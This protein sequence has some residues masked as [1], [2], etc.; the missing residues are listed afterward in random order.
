M[1]LNDVWNENINVE[2][3]PDEVH[4]E[5][6]VKKLANE[7]IRMGTY[8]DYL[9]DSNDLAEIK[10]GIEHVKMRNIKLVASMIHLFD[11]IDEG[12]IIYQNELRK[13]SEEYLFRLDNKIQAKKCPKCGNVEGKN[14][15][16]SLDGEENNK[17]KQKLYE[18]DLKKAIGDIDDFRI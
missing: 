4:K 9:I 12:D 5:L 18:E 17:V 14:I 6:T 16:Y 11:W 10:H 13:L 8:L 15:T 7:L 1:K 2:T 3:L